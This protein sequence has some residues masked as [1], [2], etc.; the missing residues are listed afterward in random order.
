MYA[1]FFSEIDVLSRLSLADQ[2]FQQKEKLPA[3]RV[4]TRD[5]T[6]IGRP[7]SRKGPMIC[8]MQLSPGGKTSSEPSVTLF[9]LSAPLVQQTRQSE[10][11]M[12]ITCV[13]ES[14]FC[15]PTYV[16]CL[17]LSVLRYFFRFKVLTCSRSGRKCGLPTHLYMELT[18]IFNV[19]AR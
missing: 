3:R 9:Y 10:L 5:L 7:L 19:I 1:L 6:G 8:E 14:R 12:L 18:W 16:R 11:P 13:I 2:G 17:A 15:P 4:E